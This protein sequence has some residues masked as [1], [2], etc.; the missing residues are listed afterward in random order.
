MI[1]IFKYFKAIP[2]RNRLICSL[3]MVHILV[4]LNHTTGD[5]GER[6]G[7]LSWKSLGEVMDKVDFFKI[8]RFLG[9]LWK[10]ITESLR[11]RYKNVFQ[12]RENALC[13][14]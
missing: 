5:L 2:E 3:S 8:S 4:V 14:R 7:R 1:T 6:L 12:K 9:R 13:W 11:V 10:S